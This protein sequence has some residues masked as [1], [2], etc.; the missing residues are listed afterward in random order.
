MSCLQKSRTLVVYDGNARPAVFE[1]DGRGSYTAPKY[2]RVGEF[3]ANGR[4]VMTF[5]DGGQ[6][7]FGPPSQWAQS[8]S[9]VQRLS[10]IVDRHGNTIELEYDAS[11]RLERVI[12]AAGQSLELT[13]DASGFISSVQAQLDSSTQRIVS[14]EH[15]A[16]ND[17]HGNE[18]DLRRATLP[19]IT[20]TVTGNDFRGGTSTTYTLQYRVAPSRAQRQLAHDSGRVGASVPH[21]HL[22][23]HDQ[24]G[25]LRV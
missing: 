5:A 23:L 22:R 21:E 8:P 4:F 18:G 3:D 13:Y 20:G 11:D 10:Q 9:Q 16:T 1:D 2:H 15:Y 12:N 7:I 17:P 24:P 19:P 6:W 25:R 14:Y